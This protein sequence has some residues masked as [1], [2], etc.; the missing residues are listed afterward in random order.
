MEGE[1]DLDKNTE[2][3]NQEEIEGEE[4]LNEEM[5]NENDNVNININ[6]DNEEE[7]QGADEIISPSN[8]LNNEIVEQHEK[9]QNLEDEEEE[10]E[11]Q[12]QE[13]KDLQEKIENL[14]DSDIEDPKY[15]P[16]YGK[17]KRIS[18]DILNLNQK[19]NFL[20]NNNNF[21]SKSLKD[22]EREN[23][24]LKS[25]IVKK[26]N[27]IQSKEDLTKEYQ[28]LLSVFKDKIE[29]SENYN[30]TFKKQIEDLKNQINQKDILISEYKKRNNS[31]EK[32][33]KLNR[34]SIIYIF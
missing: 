27:V 30:K 21:L 17:N 33:I 32:N 11:K 29:Q 34:Q 3:K 7:E 8:E 1:N 4:N 28:N 19:I 10:E 2:E 31:I 13:A 9:N 18:N 22:Y 23:A 14:T 12:Q 25:E 26:N 16:Y 20:E 15:K 6:D 24:F 5:Y